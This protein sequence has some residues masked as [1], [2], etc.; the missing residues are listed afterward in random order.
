MF[1]L[2]ANN[3]GFD[4]S[5]LRSNDFDKF[6]SKSDSSGLKAALIPPFGRPNAPEF[7]TDTTQRGDRFAFVKYLPLCFSPN[8]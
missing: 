1:S 6:S 5:C 3:F 7:F 8:V 4:F 2:L